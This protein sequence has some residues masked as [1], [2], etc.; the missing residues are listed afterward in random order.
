M[1]APY[2]VSLLYTFASMR[3][4]CAQQIIGAMAVSRTS[5]SIMRP[6]PKVLSSRSEELAQ[7]AMHHDDAQL[8]RVRALMIQQPSNYC[9]LCRLSRYNPKC[10]EETFPTRTAQE[11]C[12]YLFDRPIVPAAP[13]TIPFKRIIKSRLCVEQFA[14]DMGLLSKEIQKGRGLGKLE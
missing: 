9:V 11:A 7:A 6:Y 8:A 12:T 14:K 5:T 2:A 3:H 10:L 4:G 1:L 13:S